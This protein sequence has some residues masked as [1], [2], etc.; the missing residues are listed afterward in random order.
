MLLLDAETRAGAL[1]L[2]VALEVEPGRCLALAGPSGAGKSTLLRIAAGLVRP[3]RGHVRAG[4]ETWLDTERGIDVP[5]E[6][7]RVGF[8]F[9]D[10]ALFPHMSALDNVAYATRERGRAREIL[11]RLGIGTEA[12]V[13]LPGAL[14][15]GERQ[16]V[17]LA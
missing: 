4:S 1:D 9:Q 8:V 6:R 14:S 15:G 16:R 17:A 5:A 7:R 3:R 10:Y 13:R 11:E 2:Q 12:A